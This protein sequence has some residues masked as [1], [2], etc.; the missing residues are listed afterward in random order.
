MKKFYAVDGSFRTSFANET[1]LNEHLSKHPSAKPLMIHEWASD[2]LRINVCDSQP[3]ITSEVG[4]QYPL[5]AAIERNWDRIVRAARMFGISGYKIKSVRIQ[6]EDAK[7]VIT[8]QGWDSSECLVDFA[9]E[10][11][12][13]DE[14]LL[15]RTVV[16]NGVEDGDLH[17]DDF[18]ADL[19]KK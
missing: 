12:W 6:R 3:T 15:T 4:V 19:I 16:F 11:N 8:I 7:C 2:E 14:N 10:K 5:E 13:A 17:S 1:K 18:M 9:P